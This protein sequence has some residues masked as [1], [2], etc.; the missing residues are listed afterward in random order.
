MKTAFDRM[1][2]Q[3]TKRLSILLFLVVS[4]I[5]RAVRRVDAVCILARENIQQLGDDVSANFTQRSLQ[6]S[7]TL[8]V[9]VFGNCE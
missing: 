3:D 6:T 2:F 8:L 9:R 1:L 4:V 5:S 7:D